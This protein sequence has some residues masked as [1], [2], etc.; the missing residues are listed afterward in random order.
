MAFLRGS[1]GGGGSTTFLGLTDTPGVYAGNAGKAVAV[2]SGETALIFTDLDAPIQIVT[3]TANYTVTTEDHVLVD[4]SAGD[5]TVTLPNPQAT[6]TKPVAVKRIDT[7]ANVVTIVS[8]GGENIDGAASVN[9]PALG[10]MSFVPSRDVTDS[11][12]VE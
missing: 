6:T 4:A 7:S 2:N 10:S 11:W 5:I 3:V 8:I 12:W 1:G 9:V